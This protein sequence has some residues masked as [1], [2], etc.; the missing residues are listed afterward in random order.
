MC[1]GD[2]DTPQLEAELPLRPLVT[3]KLAE[4]AKVMSPD[5]VATRFIKG[6]EAGQFIVTYGLQLHA[7]ASLQGVIGP[8]LRV[9]QNGSKR[10][11]K[12]K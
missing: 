2:T 6:A 7:L 10:V 11:G 1:P 8:A 12:A 3:S 4:G 5:D 9:H